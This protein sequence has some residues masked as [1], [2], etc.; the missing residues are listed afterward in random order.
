MP[1]RPTATLAVA[2]RALVLSQGGVALDL[3]AAGLRQFG[4]D[5]RQFEDALLGA[6]GRAVVE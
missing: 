4:G 6:M 5:A 2:D 1:P 3:D